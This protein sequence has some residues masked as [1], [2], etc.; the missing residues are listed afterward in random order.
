MNE[1]KK[2]EQEDLNV[3]KAIDDIFDENTSDINTKNEEELSKTSLNIN[4]INNEDFDYSKV[5][6]EIEINTA[7]ESNDNKVLNFINNNFDDE[8]ITKENIT[9]D[10][11]STDLNDNLSIVEDANNSYN[12]IVY[13][14][15]VETENDIPKKNKKTLY[16]ILGAVV[17]LIL[18]IILCI[19]SINCEKKTSCSYKSDDSNYKITDEYKITYKKNR[20]LYVNG[21]YEYT[22]KTKSYENQISLIRQEKIPAMVNSNAMKG[23]TYILDEGTNKFKITS[24]L[25]FTVFDYDEINKINQ[26]TKPISYFEIDSKLT[27][28]KFKSILEKQGYTCKSI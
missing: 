9:D 26:K 8:D 2:T 23:F 27:Y 10:K 1:D 17:G 20:I 16:L 3:E 19:L 6:D 11:N 7:N 28:K 21:I 25:D 13:N 14:T 18:I 24:S 15:P 4:S 5:Q 22:A 12:N